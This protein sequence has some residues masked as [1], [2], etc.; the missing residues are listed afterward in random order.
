MPIGYIHRFTETLRRD[1]PSGYVTHGV[2]KT[3]DADAPFVPFTIDHKLGMKEGDP[4]RYNLPDVRRG[5]TEVTF[6]PVGK[7]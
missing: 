2:I 1:M 5:R 3:E 4:V 7:E 6:G